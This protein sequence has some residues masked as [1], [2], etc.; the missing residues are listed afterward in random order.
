[1]EYTIY[2]KTWARYGAFRHYCDEVPCAITMQ[3]RIDVTALHEAAHDRLPFTAVMLYC[4]SYIIN[5]REEFRLTATRDGEP[6][7]YDVVHP[8]YTVFHEDDETC[9]T[10]YTRYTSDLH[11]FIDRYREDAARARAVRTASIAMPDNTFYA[12]NLPWYDYD[13]VSLQYGP[14]AEIPLL[15]MVVFGRYRPAD[16]KSRQADDRLLLPVTLSVHHAAADGYQVSRFFHELAQVAVG[17]A[18]RL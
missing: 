10:A 11:A 12:A 16:E 9:T 4:V 6:A 2:P 17:V 14:G 8:S 5:N 15:P 13:A 7:L 3:G 18:R 1:M